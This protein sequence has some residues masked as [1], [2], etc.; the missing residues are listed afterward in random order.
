MHGA[1]RAYEQGARV[2]VFPEMTITIT[3]I[4]SLSLYVPH[5]AEHQTMQQTRS[6]LPRRRALWRPIRGYRNGG[7]RSQ[8]GAT[9]VGTS[10]SPTG[11][12]YDNRAPNRHLQP[13]YAQLMRRAVPQPTEPSEPANKCAAAERGATDSRHRQ[14]SNEHISSRAPNRRTPN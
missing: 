7:K 3:L 12:P 8:R 6:L 13:M 1:Q 11:E 9:L 14:Q 5:S 10:A 4:R 2:V